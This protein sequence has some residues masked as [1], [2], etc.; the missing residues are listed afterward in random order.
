MTATYSVPRSS[1]LHK[2]SFS[3]IRGLAW[4]LRKSS[5]KIIA[6]ESSLPS[7]SHQFG[8][9]QQAEPG[10]LGFLQ[11]AESDQLDFPPQNPSRKPRLTEAEKKANHVTSEQKRR[12]K[13]RDA[14]LRISRIVP[15]A[16]GKERSEEAL[17]RL[18]LAYAKHL[19]EQR[20]L[21]IQLVEAQGGVVEEELRQI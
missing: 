18:Y 4:L 20:E 21:L 7:D 9:P 3:I 12:Q 10:Q 2:L 14:Y 16:E 15:G 5:H 11:Q 19:K 6:M 1:L 8:F 17:L 13:I